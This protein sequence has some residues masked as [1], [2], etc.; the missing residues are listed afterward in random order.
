MVTPA[1]D[2]LHS[3]VVAVLKI[4]LPL[5]ALAI[6]SSLFLFSETNK[7]RRLCKFISTW[8]PFEYFIIGG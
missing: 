3:R 1:R 4:A 7:F 5:L 6:L 8:R 2:N